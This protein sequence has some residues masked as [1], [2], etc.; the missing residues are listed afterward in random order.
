MREKDLIGKIRLLRQ[1]KPSKDWVILT[2]SKIFE[3]EPKISPFAFLFQFRLKP[4]LA[5][6]LSFLIIFGIVTQTQN[7]L[8]GEKLYSIKKITEKV[9]TAFVSEKEKP[10]AG[11]DL[12]EKRLEE[13]DEITQ[14]NLV[15]N[16]STGIR[17]YKLAKNEVNKEVSNLKNKS[18]NEAIRIAKDMAP[19]IKI[20]NER[21]EKIFASLEIKPEETVEPA[22]KVIIELL[23][24]DVKK[25][26]L[27]DEQK[28]DLEKIEEY[29]NNG[30]Y[31]A[32]LELYLT[33]SLNQK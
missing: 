9:R 21:E 22:I 13:L 12:A 16:L 33:S 5:G 30:D 28:I 3:E 7:A 31:Q 24:Q 10:K 27:T 25:A 32:A 15:K 29:Y 26:T 8:P 20:I 11:L 6:V 1:I 17:E 18:T 23:I 4:A 2:K 14:K 19:G